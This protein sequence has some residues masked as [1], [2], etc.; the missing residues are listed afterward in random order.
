MRRAASGLPR[1]T[2]QRGLSGIRG[3]AAR[4]MM[5][6]IAT[7][8]NIHRQPNCAFQDAANIVCEICSCVFSAMRQLAICAARMP[9]TKA[10]WFRLTRRPL[11]AAGLI[12]AMYIGD[13]LEARPIAPP[14]TM[15][16]VMNVAKLDD[17]PVKTDEMA[18]SKA[19]KTRTFFRPR[20]SLILPAMSD[21][22]K[23]PTKAELFAHP[24]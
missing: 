17:H 9:I 14:P 4:K 12:S 3:I 21:P 15:R 24:T 5:D 13:T 7:A 23:H 6:G 10:S 1:A 16:H 11:H 18:K 19:E 22:T 8:V 20:L 2:S